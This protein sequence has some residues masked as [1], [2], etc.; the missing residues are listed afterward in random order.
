MFPSGSTAI[1]EG[2]LNSSG[3]FAARSTEEALILL[4]IKAL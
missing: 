4:A 1:P 2:E 3:A